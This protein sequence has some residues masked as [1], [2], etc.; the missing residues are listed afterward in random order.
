[1][2]RVDLLSSKEPN[3]SSTG[4]KDADKVQLVKIGT[5]KQVWYSL[6]PIFWCIEA[7]FQIYFL[8]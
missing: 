5:E 4:S 1:M 2:E 7:G 3:Q 6:E 8:K